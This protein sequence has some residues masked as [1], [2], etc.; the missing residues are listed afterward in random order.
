VQFGTSL[1]DSAFLG[2]V[3]MLEPSGCPMSPSSETVAKLCDNAP[4]LCQFAQLA[5]VNRESASDRL[6][7]R[8]A[9]AFRW[10]R[11]PRLPSRNATVPEE[12]ALLLSLSSAG[13][14]RW[15]TLGKWPTGSSCRFWESLLV[16]TAFAL[17]RA[18]EIQEQCF[19]TRGLLVQAIH[20]KG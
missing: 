9:D 15:I 5:A 17:N 2:R 1:T 16:G 6:S 18:S 7:F 4:D 20:Q 13:S 14:F 19:Q 8:L 11:F 3:P 10:H 12:R